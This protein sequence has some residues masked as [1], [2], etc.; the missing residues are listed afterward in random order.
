MKTS[1]NHRRRDAPVTYAEVGMVMDML[2]ITLSD[3]P[4]AEI[5]RQK[6]KS[7]LRHPQNKVLLRANQAGLSTQ[8]VCLCALQHQCAV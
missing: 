6:Q 5:V 3:I 1:H 2:S 4:E 8:S 7:L